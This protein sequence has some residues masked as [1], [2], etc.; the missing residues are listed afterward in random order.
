MFN[1]LL[2]KV[3]HNKMSFQIPAYYFRIPNEHTVT[4]FLREVSMQSTS[5]DPLFS[6]NQLLADNTDNIGNIDEQNDNENSEFQ[7][8]LLEAPM[9]C[10]IAEY[11]KAAASL[12]N[13]GVLNCTGWTNAYCQ[14]HNPSFEQ[15]Y[16]LN[17]PAHELLS[18][19]AIQHTSISCNQ[20]SEIKVSQPNIV[21][22]CLHTRIGSFLSVLNPCRI[23]EYSWKCVSLAGFNR[24]TIKKESKW[25]ITNA[26]VISLTTLSGHLLCGEE[27]FVLLHRKVRRPQE[28]NEQFG[29]DCMLPFPSIFLEN[30]KMLENENDQKEEVIFR[31]V[32]RSKPASL[33]GFISWPIIKRLQKRFFSSIVCALKS[34]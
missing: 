32:S 26:T 7:T 4:E 18:Q 1:S 13:L 33:L 16:L 9:G 10:S 12:Q 31:I 8:L 30:E 21:D 11:Y 17:H 19:P 23:R 15:S 6:I 22:V 27:H 28:C 34:S 25:D 29:K 14:T 5:Y 20:D 2:S 3:L 24:E